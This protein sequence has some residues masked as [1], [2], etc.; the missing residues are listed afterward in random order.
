MRNFLDKLTGF[1]KIAITLTGMVLAT[2]LLISGKITPDNWV[3]FHQWLLPAFLASNVL[4]KMT[5]KDGI[6]KEES[7]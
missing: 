2:T 1:R 7:N 3:S 6:A 5:G 4:S